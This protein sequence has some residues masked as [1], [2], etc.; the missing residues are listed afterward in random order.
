MIAASG[1]EGI[2]VAGSTTSNTVIA[3]NYVGLSASG[4]RLANGW[5]GLNIYGGL[6]TRV[7][8]NGD[9]VNDTD[10]R[11][12]ISG[13]TNAGIVISSN[14]PTVTVRGN[15][16]GTNVAGTAAIG[17]GA[18][19]ISFINGAQNIVVGGT[20]AAD[21]NIISGNVGAGVSISGSASNRG[22]A[23][24]GNYI[25]TDVSG[26]IDLGN[27]SDGIVVSNL[28]TNNIIGGEAVGAGNLISGNDGDGIDLTTAIGTRVQGNYIG[29][30]KD[31]TAMTSGAIAWWRGDGVSTDFASGNSG[32]IVGNTTYTTAMVGQGFSFDGQGD[33]VNIPNATQLQVQNF[34]MEGW[35]RRTSLT[36]ASLDQTTEPGGMIFS[37]GT[38]AMRWE[39]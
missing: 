29:T 16:I 1:N 22:I 2:T 10:E 36:Q 32:T 4:A 14:L 35:I 20:S 8:T 34:T 30:N 5:A 9:G 7:G 39:C 27:T 11:N 18:A 24:V 15:Y 26:T 13:N 17:N 28:A 25:G 38:A 37:Y 6:N 33:A 23:I 21:R 19:G 3:G 12:V 31:G